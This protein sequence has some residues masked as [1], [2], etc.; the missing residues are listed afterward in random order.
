MVCLSF[1]MFLLFSTTSWATGPRVTP[2][3]FVDDLMQVYAVDFPPYVSNDLDSGGLNV[4]IVD[5]VFKRAGIDVPHNILPVTNMVK[6]YLLEENALACHANQ[7]YFSEQESAKL[8]FIPIA[9]ATEKLYYLKSAH[10]NGLP[11]TGQI[12]SLKDYTYGA[13]REESINVFVEAGVNVNTGSARSLLKRLESQQA[14]FI[15]M[16]ELAINWLLNNLYTELKD[17]VI[18][19]EKSESTV[20]LYIVFNTQH[21]EG[22]SI[23]EKFKSGLDENIKQGDYLAILRKYIPEVEQQQIYMDQLNGYRSAEL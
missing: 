21:P 16:P 18:A 10:Q 23:A 22:K 3:M 9:V 7:M 17:D 1:I 20:P 11:W 12:A 15:K 6:Y 2:S 8:I 14:D 19:V 4:E 5:S 13:Y